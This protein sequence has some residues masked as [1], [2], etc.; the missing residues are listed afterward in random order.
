ML[1]GPD[2]RHPR[3]TSAGDVLAAAVSH[4][5]AAARLD[6]QGAQGGGEDLRRGLA[7]ADLAGEGHAVE[8]TGQP[9]VRELG[10]EAGGAIRRV[11]AETET[12]AAPAQLRQG[13]DR[14]LGDHSTFPPRLL[15]DG[16][17]LIQQLV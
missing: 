16:G 4:H 2:A 17:D 9:E 8:E 12:K 10:V 11:G 5:R 14:S 6:T 13:V 15:G 7:P 3:G 1:A